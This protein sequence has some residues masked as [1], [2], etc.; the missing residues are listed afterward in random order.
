[1]AFMKLGINIIP[2]Y[3]FSLS[4]IIIIIIIIIIIGQI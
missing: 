3:T 4:L 1:M 2:L